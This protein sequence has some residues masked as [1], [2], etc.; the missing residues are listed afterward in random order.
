[1]VILELQKYPTIN[2]QMPKYPIKE[3]ELSIL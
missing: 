3:D 1:M 2:L